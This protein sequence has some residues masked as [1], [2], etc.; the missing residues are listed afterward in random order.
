VLYFVLQVTWLRHAFF[1][2][3]PRNNETDASVLAGV[4]LLLA[5][6]GK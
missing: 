6:I 4:G 2:V 1:K 5:I 3:A